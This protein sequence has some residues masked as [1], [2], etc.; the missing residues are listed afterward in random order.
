MQ[1]PKLFAIQPYLS[2][3][4]LIIIVSVISQ[5]L[6][7]FFC[8]AFHL[9]YVLFVHL[10]SVMQFCTCIPLNFVGWFVLLARY[11]W[12]IVC[13]NIASITK[14]TNK[15]FTIALSSCLIFF[16][17]FSRIM[18]TSI[19]IGKWNTHTFQMPRNNNQVILLLPPSRAPDN[20]EN[21][22][23]TCLSVAFCKWLL[24]S[25]LLEHWQ[26]FRCW[27]TSN[28][29]LAQLFVNYFCSRSKSFCANGKSSIVVIIIIVC[30]HHRFWCVLY[31][32]AIESNVSHSKTITTTYLTEDGS[33]F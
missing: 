6:L 26:L 7:P 9:H 8:A 2:L 16:K 13:F 11:T 25:I 27:R 24:S 31:C 12:H 22:L 5:R 21:M 3:Y 18:F 19:L 23:E 17:F 4:I 10:L 33:S 32:C 15:R 14:Q 1:S 29:I 30:R 28:E 20:E